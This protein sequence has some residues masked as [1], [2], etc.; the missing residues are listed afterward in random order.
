MGRF[1]GWHAGRPAVFLPLGPM[2]SSADSTVPAF[3]TV[4]RHRRDSNRGA[5]HTSMS[6]SRQ[7]LR[8]AEAAA[9]HRLQ[10]S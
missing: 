4:L 9:M 1:V 3:C 2:C 5:C 7:G 10:P 8:P 6:S